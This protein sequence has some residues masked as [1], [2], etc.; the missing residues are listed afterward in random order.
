V[1][2]QSLAAALLALLV[3]AAGCVGTNQLTSPNQPTEGELPPGVSETRVENASALLDA[4]TL[5]LDESGYAY[6]LERNRSVDGHNESQPEYDEWRHQTTRVA[7]GEYHGV[8]TVTTGFSRPGYD[9]TSQFDYWW[10][11][12]TAFVRF[13]AGNETRYDRLDQPTGIG[14]AFV[15]DTWY[16]WGLL[17]DGEFVV[18]GVD[19]TVSGARIT[20]TSTGNGTRA[21]AARSYDATV[22]VDTAGRIHSATEEAVYDTDEGTVAIHTRYERT[23]TGVRSVDDPDWLDEARTNQTVV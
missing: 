9:E 16:L 15:S 8:A 23:T 17:D 20:L 10:N 4:H 19:R 11:N 13:D 18:D 3:A 14:S 7:G 12:S 21:Q 22:V 1:K 5:A 6:R 2:N